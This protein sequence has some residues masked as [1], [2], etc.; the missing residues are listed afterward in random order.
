[1]PLPNN[2]PGAWGFGTAY[3]KNYKGWNI[4]GYEPAPASLCPTG[5]CPTNYITLMARMATDNT[6][7]ALRKLYNADFVFYIHEKQWVT[8]YDGQTGYVDGAVNKGNRYITIKDAPYRTGVINYYADQSTYAHEMFHFLGAGHTRIEDWALPDNSEGYAY[9]DG[10]WALQGGQLVQRFYKTF[11]MYDWKCE[12]M[13]P[14]NANCHHVN[15]LSTT[16]EGIDLSGGYYVPIGS[17]SNDNH[18][19][20]WYRY[21]QSVTWS[22]YYNQP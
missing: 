6:V 1:M 5:T 12:D 3:Y 17:S 20:I 19:E 7:E 15:R 13:I 18:Y 2:Q 16:Y 11:M 9:Y 10:Y 8:T 14:E 21:P 4:Y 22:H